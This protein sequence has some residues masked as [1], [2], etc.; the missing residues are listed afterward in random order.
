MERVKPET[1][2]ELRYIIEK[3]ITKH[4]K[5]AN[6]NHIDVSNITNMS[7]L[8]KGI[9][10]WNIRIDKWDVYNVENMFQMFY[11]CCNFNCNLSKWDVSKV[12][13]MNFMFWCCRKFFCN[14]SKWDLRN[15]NYALLMLEG[16]ERFVEN[17][18]LRPKFFDTDYDNLA[19][20]FREYFK[21][22]YGK[23]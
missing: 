5:N 8:F 16:C 4:G 7:K 15:I 20:E 14:L 17:P 19:E 13:N 11:G 10:V 12:R 3:L 21:K 9:D 23:D 1:K 6:L 18:Q 2:E 22:V